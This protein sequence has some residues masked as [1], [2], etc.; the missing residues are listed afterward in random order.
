MQQLLLNNIICK[1]KAFLVVIDVFCDP[2]N[3]NNNKKWFAPKF[4][5]KF[6]QELENDS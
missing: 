6:S 2:K 1:V 5:S 3:T 4:H